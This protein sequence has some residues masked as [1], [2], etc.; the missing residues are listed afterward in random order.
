MR[1]CILLFLAI[2]IFSPINRAMGGIR[3]G[4]SEVPFDLPEG[5]PLGGYGGAERR[6]HPSRWKFGKRPVFFKP[7]MGTSDAV[8]S[9]SMVLKSDTGK[10]AFVSLDL[11]AISADFRKDLLE[12]LQG[13]GFHTGNLMVSATHTHSGPGGLSRNPFWELAALD[14]FRKETYRA[15][16]DSAAQAVT[17]ADADAARAKMET[18]RFEVPGA[19]RNRRNH[20]ERVDRQARLILAKAESGAILGSLVLFSVH[21]TALEDNNL[22]FSADVPGGIERGLNQAFSEYNLSHGI[23][24]APQPVSLFVNGAVG[25]IS[26]NDSD[27]DGIQRIGA[28]FATAA[29]AT[30]FRGTPLPD[31]WSLAQKRVSLPWAGFNVRNC[32]REFRKNK[33]NRALRFVPEDMDFNLVGLFFPR[34]VELTSIRWGD[35]VLAT[36]PGEPTQKLGS[37]FLSAMGNSDLEG[38]ILGLTNEHLAYFL[39]HDEFGE[40]GY[41]SC[42]SFYGQSGG[43]AILEA[44]IRLGKR[45]F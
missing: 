4:F 41:E 19:Q 21:G 17:R 24:S 45:L 34:F 20:P 26:P 23:A 14:T 35:L 29:R 43:E 22:F 16:L 39:T 31:F 44:Q 28:I 30:L 7:A 13:S 12:R 42:F 6:L 36:W 38:V 37:G 18:I 32:V 2:G 9:K 1:L 27:A 10:L 3:A 5:T 25:D 11:V 33:P 15:V 8:R 40:G